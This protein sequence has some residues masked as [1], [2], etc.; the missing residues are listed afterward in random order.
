MDDARQLVSDAQFAGVLKTVLDNNRDMAADVGARI[1][2]EA[3]K[4]VVAGA[5]FPDVPLAPSRVVDEGWHALIL[6]TRLYVDLCQ[7]FGPFV[8]HSPGYDP[9]NYDPKILE[10]TCAVIGEAG[11]SLDSALWGSPT[12]PL[13]AVAAQCQHAPECAIQPM[14]EPRDPRG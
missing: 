2:T 10:R 3:L 13:V 9:T 7:R 14:P 5:Q 4:F 11:Y 1:V 12:K 6:H 8:H